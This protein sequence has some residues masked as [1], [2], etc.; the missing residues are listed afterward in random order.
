M[1]NNYKFWLGDLAK[2]RSEMK[3]QLGKR[4][5]QQILNHQRDYVPG[6]RMP[7]VIFWQQ[8]LSQ[9][10]FLHE[11]DIFW[12]ASDMTRQVYCTRGRHSGSDRI[13]GNSFSDLVLQDA[14]CKSIWN[15]GTAK[16]SWTFHFSFAALQV[17]AILQQ[18]DLYIYFQQYGLVA[19]ST[20]TAQL[21]VA[22]DD[23]PTHIFALVHR[24]SEHL[25]AETPL[26]K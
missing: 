15:E 21:L 1:V 11:T 7:S 25:F 12:Q 10:M 13:W 16:S 23:I 3:P 2:S 22:F 20:S 5:N 26:R 17:R 6:L 24:W 14:P 18:E 9:N 19:C 8:C 4:W